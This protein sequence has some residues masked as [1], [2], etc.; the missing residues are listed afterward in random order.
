MAEVI[1]P[2]L[3]RWTYLSL[4]LECARICD[5][6][7]YTPV[8]L[9]ETSFLPPVIFLICLCELKHRAGQNSHCRG[10]WLWCVLKRVPCTP[11]ANNLTDWTNR[12]YTKSDWNTILIH[13]DRVTHIRVNR[14][15][16]IGSDNGLSPDRRQAVI[17]TNA[18]ILLIHTLGTNFSE[19]LM[20]NSYISMQENAFE[21]VVCEMKKILFRSEYVNTIDLRQRKRTHRNIPDTTEP[22]QHTDK[23][24]HLSLKLLS[25]HTG[26]VTPLYPILAHWGQDKMSS[27]HRRHFQVHF[28]TKKI[29]VFRFKFHWNLFLRVQ[30]TI[31]L[32]WFR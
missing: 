20:R 13:W 18:G 12:T 23:S 14:L 6:L 11:T 22:N 1:Y 30:L 3:G 28:L 16:N 7:H 2:W 15:T 29:A 27:F 17:W 8:F 25:A 21:S 5:P 10:I 9:K 4:N 24:G 26:C 19:I 32:H 31:S